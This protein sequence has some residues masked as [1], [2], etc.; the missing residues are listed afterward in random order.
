MFT[1]I[2]P[3]DVLYTSKADGL[4]RSDLTP[5]TIDDDPFGGITVLTLT[6]KAPAPAVPIAT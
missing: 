5:I 4:G 6:F 1:F 3:A 2:V